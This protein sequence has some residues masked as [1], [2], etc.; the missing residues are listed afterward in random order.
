MR[1]G[2]WLDHLPP[3][4]AWGAVAST[5]A[6]GGVEVAAMAIPLLAAAAVEWRNTSLHRF[7]RI[8]ELV[9]L[10]VFLFQVG[11]R[12]GVLPT[13]VNTLFALCGV[14]L[15][16][17]RE[18]PQR[19]QLLLMGFL[20]YLTTAVSTSELD[21]LAWSLAW[22]AGSGLYL[23]QLN[24]E[25]SGQLRGGPA[26]SPPYRRIL[27]WTAAAMV[28]AAGFFV[29]LPRLRTGMRSLPLA[30]HS[31][32]GLRAGLSD[33]LDLA[34][35]GP[36]QGNSEVV[37]RIIPAR[38]DPAFPGA[39]GLLRGL[40]LE[41]L[42]GQRWS[43]AESTP[44]DRMAAWHG[45]GGRFYRQSLAAEIFLSPSELAVIP[46]PYGRANLE[47]PP[48]EQLR[49]GPGASIRWLFPIRRI[50]SINAT[51]EP[52]ALEPEPPPTGARL[53][54]LT[55]P[56][57]DTGSAL[58]WSLRQAPGEMD[59][60]TL[61]AT[62]AKA[63]H[64]FRYTL[65]NPSGSA[66]NPLQDFLEHSQAG[67]CEFFASALAVMLRHRGVPARVVNGYRLGP[68]LQE[69]GY[70]L[71]TQQEAHSWVEFYDP[72]QRGWV[73]VDPTPPAPPS[74]FA[75]HSMMAALERLAD[76]VRFRWDRNVVRFSDDDQS[77]G[78]DWLQRRLQALA[79]HRA[80]AAALAGLAGLAGLAWALRR[81]PARAGVHGSPGA[82]RE[83]R[84]LLRAA[85]RALPPRPG[86]TALAWLTRLGQARPDRAE[87]LAGL[88]RE[89]DAVAYGGKAATSLVRLARAEARAWKDG[90][91]GRA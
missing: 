42:E 86:E 80:G 29:I 75:T 47:P 66:R 22:A 70:Y 32:T 63:L 25:R 69:G 34:E 40:V 72:V 65:A 62:L 1:T 82:V 90:G 53:E 87:A 59:A 76:T 61:A 10:G 58:R 39:F 77:A 33:T 6:Y 3:W 50:L 8:L 9:A 30:V 7:R 73:P 43:M 55:S 16:L 74:G 5:G 85:G 45:G 37:L 19:R 12:T 17:P 56:G 11:A 64:R 20:L 2:R 54:F 51:L 21:F 27:G 23:M 81:W 89:T 83:I 24:W 4:L 26:M 78:F 91:P 31:M 84:P 18:L 88:A 38:P 15:C 13:V 67:H 36:L 48:G 60:A 44:P 71:V 57:R 52:M 68:W 79:R 28:M 35:T 46:L 41:D 14:R 49:A